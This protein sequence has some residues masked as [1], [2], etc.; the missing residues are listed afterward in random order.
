MQAVGA[1]FV[2]QPGLVF[3]QLLHVV[4][5][6][7]LTLKF[8]RVEVAV[9]H[10][11]AEQDVRPAHLLD[12]VVVAYPMRGAQRSLSEACL[13]LLQSAVHGHRKLLFNVLQLLR[14]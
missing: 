1:A 11:F 2:H 7:A 9:F 4:L 12:G 3:A 13:H 10:A 6:A 8:D 5:R 14:T